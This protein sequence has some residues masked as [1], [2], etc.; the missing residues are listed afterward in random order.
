MVISKIK[1][2]FKKIRFPKPKEALL[3]SLLILGISLAASL[4]IALYN[5]GLEKLLNLIM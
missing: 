2:T 4:V 5:M 3:N 1:N